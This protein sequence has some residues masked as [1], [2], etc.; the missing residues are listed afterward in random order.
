MEFL[1]FEGDFGLLSFEVANLFCELLSFMDFF[2]SLLLGVFEFA[3]KFGD[4]F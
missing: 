1:F 3:L 2:V 4:L